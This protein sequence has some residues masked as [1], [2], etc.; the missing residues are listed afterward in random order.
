MALAS[1]LCESIF[2]VLLKFSSQFVCIYCVTLKRFNIVFSFVDILQNFDLKESTK[3][4]QVAVN[5]SPSTENT[6]KNIFR[7]P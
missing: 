5:E 1:P 3:F 4:N 2:P 7:F 6:K